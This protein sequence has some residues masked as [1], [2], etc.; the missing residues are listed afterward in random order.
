LTEPHT[1]R[2]TTNAVDAIATQTLGGTAA[3]RTDDF[4]A[5]AIAVALVATNAK[6]R[7]RIVGA[8][9]GNIAACADAS[10]DVA[11]LA[12]RSTCGLAANTIGAEIRQ[13]RAVR[14]TALTIH[15]I[16]IIGAIAPLGS[17]GAI[18]IGPS[19]GHIRTR[20]KAARHVTGSAQRCARIIATNPV[21]TIRVRAFVP[22]SAGRALRFLARSI[23]IASIVH[24][25]AA[26]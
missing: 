16:A 14:R 9:G 26:R 10:C 11:R 1:R 7:R 18:G 21:D 25:H 2:A 13:T 15:E 6:V 24:A 12:R 8:S 22:R 3:R 5:D 19:L 20:S 23:A 17:T 4:L